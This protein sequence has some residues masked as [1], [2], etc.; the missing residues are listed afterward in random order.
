[1]LR[2]RW[3][4]FDAQVAARVLNMMVWQSGNARVRNMP[5]PAHLLHEVARDSVVF[6]LRHQAPVC[7]GSDRIRQG[8]FSNRTLALREGAQ[9]AVSMVTLFAIGTAAVLADPVHVNFLLIVLKVIAFTPLCVCYVYDINATND[10]SSAMHLPTS[11]SR[12][13]IQKCVNWHGRVLLAR[14]TVHCMRYIYL[15]LNVS[16]PGQTAA[17]VTCTGN[18][19]DHWAGPPVPHSS[20]SGRLP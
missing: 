15:N 16:F 4:C 10:V 18:V 12:Q 17:N 14:G 19:S 3:R 2:L 20:G 5:L 6:L 8:R 7:Q 11:W 13:R 9:R 1:M